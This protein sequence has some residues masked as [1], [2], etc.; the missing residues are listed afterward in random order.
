MSESIEFS[1]FVD[2]LEHQGEIDGPVVVSVTRSRFSGNHQDFAHGLVEARLDSPF[3][4][5]SII[6]GWSAFVQPRRADGWYVEHRP[7]ATGAGITSEHPVVM[8]VEAE[9]IRLEARCEELAKA[10]WDFWSHQDLERYVTP[11]LLS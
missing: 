6:S 5:L 9:Q 7:D 3:G 1:S 10:A 4:R 8:T 2:W 11:H